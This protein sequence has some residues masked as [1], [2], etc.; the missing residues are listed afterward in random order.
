MCFLLT[1][2]E[3]SLLLCVKFWKTLHS[4]GTWEKEIVLQG[5]AFPFEFYRQ[6]CSQGGPVQDFLAKMAKFKG[7][8][9]SI[10]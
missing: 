10:H 8:R 7:H 2:W 6:D 4:F 9:L 5:L 1:D 3:L